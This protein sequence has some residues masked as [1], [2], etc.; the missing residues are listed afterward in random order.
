MGAQQKVSLF[1]N[2]Q[3]RFSNLLPSSTEPVHFEKTK[4]VNHGLIRK[5]VLGLTSPHAEEILY[6]ACVNLVDQI[7]VHHQDRSGQIGSHCFLRVC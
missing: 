6:V 4:D 5:S 1:H 3:L 2:R 7:R